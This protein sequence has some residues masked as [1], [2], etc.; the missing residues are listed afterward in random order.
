MKS[1]SVSKW[2][3]VINDFPQGSILGPVLFNIFISNINHWL[4]CTLST[5]ADETK[6]NDAV[7]TTEERDAIQRD[8][9]R[10]K[11]SPWEPNEIQQS[12]VQGVALGSG[13]SQV[14]I[15]TGRTTH[16]EQLCREGLGGPGG[17]K[18]DTIQKCTLEAQKGNSTLGASKE[19]WPA[20]GERI[21]SPPAL[22]RWIPIWSTVSRPG[23]PSTGRMWCCWSGSKGGQKYDQRAG[24]PLLWRKVGGVGLVQPGEDLPIPEGSL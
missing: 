5:F 7:D 24:T 4:E 14:C 1:A 13:Q 22:P 18:L 23:V 11:E 21:T 12:Q 10:Q 17:W 9:D 8:L 15:E 6:L 20:G 16:W 3:L 19:G 2:K